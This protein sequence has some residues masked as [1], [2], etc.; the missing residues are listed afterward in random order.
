[1]NICQSHDIKEEEENKKTELIW[2]QSSNQAAQQSL[3]N[4]HLKIGLF[5]VSPH[6]SPQLTRLG[7]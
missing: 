2:L 4:P 1:M 7:T 3:Y 5:S 6:V